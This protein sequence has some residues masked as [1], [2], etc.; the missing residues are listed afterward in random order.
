MKQKIQVFHNPRCSKSRCSLDYL[1]ESGKEF[2]VIE[3]L[4]DSPNKTLLESLLKKLNMTAFEL[5]RKGELEYKENFKGKDLS[6]S[7][8]ID[9][10]V[11]FPK[12]IE[13]PII[14]LGDKAV[15]GR[16]MERINE[17]FN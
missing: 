14:V 8:W 16:P 7:D 11:Q 9:A 6:E 13:R 10:M 2:E 5:I 12:L 17:L 1:E 3:Y 15:I 4:K